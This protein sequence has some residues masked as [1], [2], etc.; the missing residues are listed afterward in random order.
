[1]VRAAV[2][3]WI[4]KLM[5]LNGSPRGIAGGFSLGMSLS[6]IPIPAAGMLV[7]LALA[8]R[9]RC[10][11]PATYLGTA[12][13]NPLTG[14]LIYFSELWLGLA[15]LGR[16]VPAWEHM[17][18]LDAMGWWNELTGALLPFLLGGLVCAV[19]GFALSYPLLSS[20]TRRWQ[21]RAAAS[22]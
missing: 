10:N 12:V 11:L 22:T 17:R 16:E 14:P 20:L 3:R 2:R 1:M 7:S 21:A 5:A 15:I 6:L 18:T 19:V 4:R 9:L 13:V 8:P